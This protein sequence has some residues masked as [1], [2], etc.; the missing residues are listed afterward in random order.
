MSKDNNIDDFFKEGLGKA[1]YEF[2]ADNWAQMESML[3]QRDKSIWIKRSAITAAVSAVIGVASFIGWNMVSTEANVNTSTAQQ[4][5]TTQPMAIVSNDNDEQAAFVTPR[6]VQGEAPLSTIE[7]AS[8]TPTPTP[9]QLANEN[10]IEPTRTT[11]SSSNNMKPPYLAVLGSNEDDLRNVSNGLLEMN[12][13]DAESFTMSGVQVENDNRTIDRMEMIAVR[14][15]KVNQ[16]EAIQFAFADPAEVKT[17]NKR[18]YVSL[19]AGLNLSN[20]FE[21]EG[22]FSSI[23]LQALGIKYGYQVSNNV[24]LETGMVYKSRNGNGA[25]LVYEDVEY[26]FG[27][28][29]TTTEIEAKS[30][31]YLEIPLDLRYEFIPKHTLIVGASVS[32]LL[33]VKSAVNTTTEETV[34]GSSSTSETLWGHQYGFNSTDISIRL[35]YDYQIARKLNL[36]LVAGYGLMDLTNDNTFKNSEVDNSLELRLRIQYKLIQF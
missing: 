20:G 31:H 4:N 8:A 3:N 28:T 21:G 32:H 13:S 14:P 15:F 33:N 19:M 35:G 7:Q 17:R 10:I 26:G 2:N 29:I 36:G 25:K 9:T 22:V 30:L 6:S 27:S 34:N 11:P 1:S 24:V 5:L 16:M 12:I 23:P 18:S